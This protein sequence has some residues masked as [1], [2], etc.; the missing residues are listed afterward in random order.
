MHGEAHGF[1]LAANWK[2]TNRWT[3]SPGYGFEQIHMHLD[4]GSQDTGS[5]ADAE[6]G[7]PRHS[8]QLRSHFDLP[9]G[10]GWDT[11]AYFVDRLPVDTVP[12]YTRLDSGISMRLAERVSAGI[13]GQN[14]IRDRHLEFVD[15]SGN[16]RST[17]IKRSVYGKLILQF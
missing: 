3:L 17:L 4:P 1:E 12:S 15:D 14:L 7:S 5:V 8:A 10:L 2:V 16:A 11:A 6:G 13:F 9:G